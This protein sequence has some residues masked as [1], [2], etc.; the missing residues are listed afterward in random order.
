MHHTV[1]PEVEGSLEYRFLPP[2]ADRNDGVSIKD[3]RAR[4]LPS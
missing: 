3:A 1:R 2:E 4:N